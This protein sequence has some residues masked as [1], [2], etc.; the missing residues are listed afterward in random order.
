MSDCLV[1]SQTITSIFRFLQSEVVAI[2]QYETVALS[3]GAIS[4]EANSSDNR[5]SFRDNKLF[6]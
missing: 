4:N 3:V 6:T 1:D 2:L 5:W